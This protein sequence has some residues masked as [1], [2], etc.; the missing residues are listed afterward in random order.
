MEIAIHT[1]RAVASAIVEPSNAVILV[2]IALI[3]YNKNKKISAM[4]KMIMGE[5]LDSPFELTISQL[6]MGIFAGTV[7]SLIFSLLGLVFDESSNIHLLFMV[8]L[9]FMAFKPRFICFSYSGAVLGIISLVLKYAASLLHMPQLN[10]INIDILTLMTLVGILHIIEGSLVM[11]DGSRGAIPV[12]TN[13]DNKIMGGFALKRYWALPVAIFIL[14]NSATS[15]TVIGQS[16]MT[17]GWWPLIKGDIMSRIVENS[18]IVSIALYGVIGYSSITFT[19]SKKNKT[20]ASGALIIGYGILLA[21][22]SQLAVLGVAFQFFILILAAVL[23]ELMLR[24]EKYLELTGKPKFVSNEEGIM[25]LEV[26]P[27]SPAFQMGIESGDLIVQVNDKKIEN[28]EEIFSL[29]KGN[30]NSLSFKLKKPSGELKDINYTN[31]VANKRLG[32]V[33][34]PREV[35][36]D[37]AIVKVDDEKF[38]DV[39]EKMKDKDKE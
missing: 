19:K 1:L 26:A 25:V 14:L 15:D 39:L 4:Q 18:V 12:F 17:P 30:Y 2:M 6:V 35:P 32:I 22:V 20:L 9:L 29:I 3:F 10:F 28:E 11:L 23:H 34:V 7:A 33:V 8:S 24:L 37:T 5:S 36:K 16:I 13:R 38:K 21:A 31:I 27:K